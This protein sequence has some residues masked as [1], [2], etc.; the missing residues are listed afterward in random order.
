MFGR[1]GSLADLSKALADRALSTEMGVHLD[2]ERAEDA[3]EGESQALNRRNGRG[4]T[5]VTTDRGTVGLDSPRGRTGTFD[6]LLIAKYQ[7]RVPAFDLKI[8]SMYAREIQGHIAEIHGVAALPSLICAITDAVTEV[9]LVRASGSNAPGDRLKAQ[10]VTAWQTRP[11]EPCDPS[12]FM[13]AI[14]VT[15]RGNGAVS[16]KAVI[17][18]LAGLP[19][20]TRD[21]LGQGAQG[22]AQSGRPGHPQCRRG[23]AEGG[24]ASP[25]PDLSRSSAA[26]FQGLCQLHV[27][28]ALK[29]ICTA[30]EC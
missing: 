20:G 19:D 21:V 13:G 26:P 15:I 5:T 16:N 22:P 1:T 29:A 12:V 23:R 4:Q 2:V 7:R 27:A 24:P 10:S 14:R 11:L 8:V 25:D 30:V 17:V 28:A 3:S 18:A 9:K 6:P